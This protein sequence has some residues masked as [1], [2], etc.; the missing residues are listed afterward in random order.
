MS[1]YQ[2]YEPWLGSPV[3]DFMSRPMTNADPWLGRCVGDRDRYRLDRRLGGGGMGEVFLA[4]DT[5]LDQPVALKLLGDKLGTHDLRKRFEREVAVS[6]ALRSQHIVHISD[7]GVMP[8]GHPFYVMEYLEGQT[9]DQLLWQEKRLSVE[10]TVHIITQ[11][12]AGLELAHGGVYL[13]QEDK[14]TTRHVKVVHRDLKPANI[15]L[16]PTALG[17]LVKILDFGIAKVHSDQ[18]E[19]T[20]A[21]NVF[22]G[23]FRYAAPEQFEVGQDI[24]ERTD[25]YSLGMILYKM[26]TGTNPFGFDDNS[27]H[28]SGA[29]WGVAHLSKPILPLRIQPRC[30]HISPEL[31]AVVMRCLEKSPSDRFPSVAKLSAALT[32]AMSSFEGSEVRGWFWWIPRRSKDNRSPSRDRS[33]G[34]LAVSSNAI[35][36]PDIHRS[37]LST[38]A[39]ESDSSGSSPGTQ[40]TAAL[41][42]GRL[43]PAT[44]PPIYWQLRQ[45]L[46][47]FTGGSILFAIVIGAFY[48]VRSSILL[49]VSQENAPVPASIAASQAAIQAESP[50]PVPSVESDAL[51]GHS[52]TVWT[53]A[54][55][56]ANQTVLSGSY[57]KTIKI[58]DLA[59]GSLQHTL[60]GHT[61]AVRDVAVSVDGKTLVSGSGDTTIKIWD[62]TTRTVRHTLS[63]HSG[64]V[65]SVTISP[66]T[67]WLASGSYDGT[68]KIWNLKTGE[69]VRTLPEHYDSVWSVAISSDG[70]TLAS[71]SYDG[72]VK[73]WSLQT[74][75]L[76][77]TLKGHADGVRSVAIS[78]NGQFL[79]SGSWDK[80]VKVWNLS[81]G[82]LLHTL[83]GHTDRVV[84]VAIDASG[85]RIASGS[86]DRTI[87]IWDLQ[88]GNLRQTLSGHQDWVNAV[89]FSADGK[90]LI[91]GSKD[92]TVRI[93]RL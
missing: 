73:L 14:Q 74:G 64:P 77:R 38:F 39:S 80:T 18:A 29:A 81:T 21:T 5:L 51:S 42:G 75:E 15:F 67:Q 48:T 70:K 87:K 83:A 2:P 89:T 58:W 13:R 17:E 26:L 63:G 19:M 84:T 32:A 68:V 9:L 78:P 45:L 91:S 25:I 52:D 37:D 11:I 46:L 71:G 57:D 7:Y 85:Q 3:D 24:D 88:S 23:T 22:L 76:L 41:I 27:S 36:E 31:E 62:L 50:S 35:T 10:R 54:T 8:E 6:A 61:D 43:T 69:L 20:N 86:L 93:W 30:D 33:K 59:T 4:T 82:E 1:L 90:H 28:V 34:Q 60:E 92:K 65:W 44:P 12:C 72:T 66:D 79:V 47:L 53:V 55:S 40:A 56:A 49:E 16:V